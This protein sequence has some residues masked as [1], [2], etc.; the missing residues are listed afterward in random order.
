MSKWANCFLLG[1]LLAARARSA[2]NSLTAEEK[3]QG[4]IL[5][6]DGKTLNGWEPV[7]SAAPAN[8]VQGPP[9]APIP[10]QTGSHP[11]PC[12]G[13][14]RPKAEGASHWE[15]LRGAISPC[16]PPS[17]FL[18]SKAVY[19]DFILKVDFRTSPEANS[20]V[21]IR[22]PEGTGGYEVQIWRAQ[23]AGFNTGS[24]VSVAK[25][26]REYPI[27]G[28]DWNHYEITAD[29]DHLTVLLNGAQTLDVHDA[30]F[31]EGFV[32]LQY[33]MFPIEFRNLKLKPIRH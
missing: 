6:F 33:Q 8:P 11:R 30:R 18:T 32:R 26:T 22:T 20:G 23:P 16:G 29:G 7:P 19:R 3:A 25:T 12:S 1:C 17:G 15:V 9:A 28:G 4:W 14:A 2:E 21:F 5:L 13:A 10:G 31:T 27:T 24:I